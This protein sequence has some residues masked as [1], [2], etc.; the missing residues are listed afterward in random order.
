MVRKALYELAKKV[1]VIAFA[2][3]SMSLI[4]F[5]PVDVPVYMIGESGFNKIKDLMN[6]NQ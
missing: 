1:D 4:K 2:Q 6:S 3:I 5:D